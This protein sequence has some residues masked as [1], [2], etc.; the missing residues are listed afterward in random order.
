MESSEVHR[1]SV[2]GLSIEQQVVP[3]LKNEYGDAVWIAVDGERLS[4]ID[5]REYIGQPPVELLSDR[6]FVEPTTDPHEVILGRCTCGE[7][8]CGAVTARVYALDESTVAWDSLQAGNPPPPNL[9]RSRPA[10]GAILFD[11][12][13]YR[14]AIAAAK[15]PLTE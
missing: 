14:A 3:G 2:L 10:P 13:Q 8:G 12:G 4:S 7:S 5:G 15:S 9:G 6:H 1:R 11:R